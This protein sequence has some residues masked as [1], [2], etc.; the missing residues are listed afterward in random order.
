M[1]AEMELIKQAVNSKVPYSYLHFLQ[2][3]DLPIKRHEQLILFFEVH[4]GKEFVHVDKKNSSWA[5]TCCRYYYF[6][7]HNRYYRSSKFLKLL[8]IGIA[9]L[10]Q[11]LNVG[12]NKHVD[13]WYGSALFSIT[14]PFAQYVVSKEAEIQHRFRW[15]LAPDE[16]FLQTLLMN[17]PFSKN[18]VGDALASTN[19][20][21][22]DWERDRQ[23]NS[24]HVWRKEE[25]SHLLSMSEHY[26]YAR[27]FVETVDLEIVELLEAHLKS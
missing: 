22:I 4:E 20:M 14:L 6:F 21:L 25:L 1:Q 19:A 10:Q 27:K 12:L 11:C 23:K 18:L 3:S 7:C 26:C 16:K 5:N 2:N 13:F 17:S 15:A 9:R 24:P 8:N